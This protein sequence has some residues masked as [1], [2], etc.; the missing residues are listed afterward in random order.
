MASLVISFLT[1]KFG[2]EVGLQNS[3]QG[4]GLVVKRVLGEDEVRANDIIESVSGKRVNTKAEFYFQLLGSRGQ[5]ELVVR[6]HGERFIRPVTS[7]SFS[8]GEVPLGLRS[9]DRAV[10]IA[11]ADG[12]YT[13]LEGM[14]F[15]ALRGIV[16][17]FEGNG[18]V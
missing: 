12:H 17:E 11:G 13:P 8:G 7:E 15:S 4:S 14:D 6:R 1:P 18:P 9:D 5:V 16:A 2:F 3:S 10:M